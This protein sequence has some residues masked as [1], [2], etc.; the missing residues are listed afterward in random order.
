MFSSHRTFAG[1]P[2]NIRISPRSCLCQ[3]FAEG[4]N[5]QHRKALIGWLAAITHLLLAGSCP[6]A[7]LEKCQ[8]LRI[9]A[10]HRSSLCATLK[11]NRAPFLNWM[12]FD[13]R[14]PV[15]WLWA[16]YSKTHQVSPTRALRSSSRRFEELLLGSPPS[17]PPASAAGNPEWIFQ[18]A[19]K[20][21][22]RSPLL[23]LELL[24]GGG[25]ILLQLAKLSGEVVLAARQ[26]SE[27]SFLLFRGLDSWFELV[28]W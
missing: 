10:F 2:Y 1:A 13:E 23:C 12:D 7:F 11:S 15:P 25:L 3:A 21:D 18:G 28:V 14:L 6:P 19:R 5:T 27:F 17:P 8:A 4:L 20:T 26:V 24:Q 9:H 22:G 16:N